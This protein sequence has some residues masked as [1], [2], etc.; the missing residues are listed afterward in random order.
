VTKGHISQ[1]DLVLHA[2]Q[3]LPGEEDAVVAS[4]LG[5]CEACRTELASVS[6]ELAL[7]ALG[8][9]QQPLPPGARH[10][11][12]GRISGWSA[13]AAQQE[14]RVSAIGPTGTRARGS[15]IPWIA[16]AALLL[17]CA[18]LGLQIQRLDRRLQAQVALASRLKAEQAHAEEVLDVLTAPAAQRVLLTATKTP[19]SPSGRAVYLAARGALLFEANHLAPVS[20]D[21]TYELWVIPAN[22]SAPIPAGLFRPD[23]GGNASLVLPSLPAGVPAKAFGVTIEKA[24]GSST[25]TAPILLSGAA[26]ATGE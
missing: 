26:S 4:H 1:E 17:V 3:A 25:P 24:Q 14:G 20:D 23:A 9:E 10:R 13:P 8:V 21:K 15:W 16:V 5:Q 12:M 2:M 18:S 6:G 11:F 7:V 19:P 22:G